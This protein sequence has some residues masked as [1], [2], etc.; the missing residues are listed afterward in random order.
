MLRR[1]DKQHVFL[2]N[3]EHLLE[4]VLFLLTGLTAEKR[5]CLSTREG[6]HAMESTRDLP[7]KPYWLHQLGQRGRRSASSRVAADGGESA[8]LSLPRCAFF[9][10]F[11]AAGRQFASTT[12]VI[13]IVLYPLSGL[14]VASVIWSCCRFSKERFLPSSFPKHEAEAVLELF[15]F[16]CNVVTTMV[17]SAGHT[18]PRRLS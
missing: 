7:A 8:S 11:F 18:W 1:T 13:L 14:T 16:V 15:S 4:K 2:F 10:F 17:H 12:L 9:F 6:E 3:L 5:K